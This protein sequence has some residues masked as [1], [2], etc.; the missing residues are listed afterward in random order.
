MKK[1]GKRLATL[2]ERIGYSVI[3]NW[4]LASDAQ[5]RYLRRLFNYLDTDCVLDV[6]ANRG[7]YGR[8]LRD[9]VG[10]RGLIVS[11]EPITENVAELRRIAAADG[12]WVIKDFALGQI[13]GTSRFNVMNDSVFSS[14]R[15]PRT[16]GVDGMFTGNSVA[17]R[18]DVEV[19]TLK[20]VLPELLSNH[21]IHSVYLKLDTQGFDLDVLRGAGTSLTRVR[22]LQTEASVKPIY[23]GM[24]GYRETIDY[25]ISEG[26]EISA[27][28]PVSEAGFPRLIEFDCHMVSRAAIK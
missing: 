21:S 7:Q 24:P 28:F 14:F 13:N 25:L 18:I 3:P 1:L 5:G 11:F 10:Y 27:F 15:T 19:K 8:F 22:A 17:R 20:S 23:E 6:G 12:A 4:R 16:D 9:Q 26:F 2:M